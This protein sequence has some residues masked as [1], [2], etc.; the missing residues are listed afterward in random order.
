MKSLCAVNLLTMLHGIPDKHP[1]LNSGSRKIHLSFRIAFA[2]IMALLPGRLLCQEENHALRESVEEILAFSEDAD[3]AAMLEE[4]EGLKE[5]PVN[6]NSG[7]ESEI[8]RLFFLTE[9]QVMVL[10]DHVRKNGSVVTLYELAL[11][12]AF[13][14][15]TVLLMAPY[16]SLEPV[17]PNR[18]KSYGRTLVTMTASSRFGRD[19]NDTEG[20]R[21]LLKVKH[22][23]GSISFG[24]AAENDPGEPF[25]FKN[26]PGSDFLSGYIQYEGKGFINRIIA[27][28]FAVRAGEGLLFNSSRWMGSWLSSPSFMSG[29]STAA[30]YTSTEENS[31]FRGVSLTLGSMNAGAVLFASSNKIDA[32]LLFA[33]DSTATGVSNL[34]RGGIHV[35]ESQLEARNSLTET[36]AGLRLI[37][38]ADKVRGGVTAAA[39]WFSLPFIPDMTKPENLHAFTGDRLLNLAADIR[40]G[41]G[42]VLFFAEAGLSLANP[43]TGTSGTGLPDPQ[44]DTT[45]TGFPDSASAI[46]GL[47]LRDSWA[48]TAGLRAK[49]S[50]RVTFNILARHF[51]PG[52]HAFHSGAFKAGSG[53]GNETGLSASVHLEA[54]RHLFVTAAADHYRIPWPRYRSSSPSYGSRIEIR[55]EYQPRDDISMRLSW[56]SLSREYDAARETGTARSVIHTRQQFGFV[57]DISPAETLRLTTRASASLI[58]PSAEKGY[59][60]CQ[61]FTYTFR[62]IPLRLWFRYAMC[63][64]GGWDSRLYAWEN[65]LLNSFS[66]P[67]MY[68][69]MTRSFVMLSWKPADRLEVRLKYGFT[70]SGSNPGGGLKQEVKGQVRFGF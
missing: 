42:S 43:L 44:A 13:D 63:S 14:R 39:T 41:T 37:A 12:P 7:D 21:S 35:S 51:A 20:I 46:G 19:E 40:A 31:F 62:T 68:G 53:S 36:V 54:A 57:F 52:Y 9:F 48:V 59:L 66:V 22:E 3:P 50:G 49:P 4:L 33:E 6:V 65:D 34:V 29:R 16:I 5:S 58:A 27:G 17:A 45:G 15:N 64:S 1:D 8:S 23:Q 26:A 47:N 18:G 30:P 61:D 67:A 70:D 2:I 56:T 69:E 28:D 25:T 24:L 55:G 38:G 11:L 32:R 10:A 60:L